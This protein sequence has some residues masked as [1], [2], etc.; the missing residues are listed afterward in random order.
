[1]IERHVAH[2]PGERFGASTNAPVSGAAGE[3]SGARAAAGHRTVTA[4]APGTRLVARFTLALLPLDV[5]FTVGAI[6][7]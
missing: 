2:Q 7:A 3:P 6:L 5:A 4:G 1:M